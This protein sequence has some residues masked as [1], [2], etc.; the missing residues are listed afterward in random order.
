MA[1]V[2]KFFIKQNDTRPTLRCILLDADEL[3]VNLTAAALEFHMR[4]YPAGTTKISAGTV[5][6][7]DTAQGEV[8]YKWSA[9]DTDTAETYEAE[10]E[11]T[12]SDG[13]IQTFPNDKHAFVYITD[14]IA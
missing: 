2:Q 3:P 8:E 4:V 13:T 11:V 10:F 6:V 14:D 9:S 1:A 5:S 7:I 12:F